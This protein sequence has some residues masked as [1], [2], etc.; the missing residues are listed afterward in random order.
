[1]LIVEDENDIANIIKDYL[2][3]HQF[4]SHIVRAAHEAIL[5]LQESAPDFVILDLS[6]PDCD[7]I[8]ICRKIREHSNVA[9][10][11]LSAR[12]SVTDKVLGLGFSADD[13]MTKPFSLSEL[14][15]ITNAL[16]YTSTGDTITITTYIEYQTLYIQ[17]CFRKKCPLFSNVI[18]E[19][20]SPKES[21]LLKTKERG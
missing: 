7:G 3:V 8:D 21:P 18:L 10:L 5:Y 2:S 15:A 13:Y 19:V 17:G 16:K 4:H 11:S 9:I 6:L 12:R 1:M 14:V 20:A